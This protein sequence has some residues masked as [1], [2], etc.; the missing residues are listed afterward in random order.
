MGQL[1]SPSFAKRKDR[2]N[3]YCIAGVDVDGGVRELLAFIRPLDYIARSNRPMPWWL[4]AI[5][6]APPSPQKSAPNEHQTPGECDSR[7]SSPHLITAGTVHST[8]RTATS[9]AIP[10]HHIHL[11]D[12]RFVPN[13]KQSYKRTR[14]V[15]GLAGQGLYLA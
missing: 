9:L 4:A 8:P 10:C 1:L 13:T 12:A 11:H 15:A 3:D 7:S 14:A 2:A 6:V 5:F